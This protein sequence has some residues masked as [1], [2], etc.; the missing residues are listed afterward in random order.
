MLDKRIKRKGEAEPVFALEAGKKFTTEQRE[1]SEI[2]RIGGR[3]QDAWQVG[4]SSRGNA[5]I[6]CSS[7]WVTMQAGCSKP[8]KGILSRTVKMTERCRQRMTSHDG[9]S[10]MIVAQPREIYMYGW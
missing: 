5:R 10:A 4:F 1:L 6:R 2:G 3:V 7:G 9:S 8:G